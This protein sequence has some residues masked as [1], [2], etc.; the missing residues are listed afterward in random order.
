[1]KRMY[2]FRYVI[3]MLL[4]K[5]ERAWVYLQRRVIQSPYSSLLLEIVTCCHYSKR[6]YSGEIKPDASFELTILV[7]S[8]KLILL[9]K[10]WTWPVIRVYFVKKSTFQWVQKR[11]ASFYHWVCVNISLFHW[12]TSQWKQLVL[13]CVSFV[14]RSSLKRSSVCQQIVP[15]VHLTSDSPYYCSLY[16]FLIFSC[17]S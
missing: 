5:R 15:E 11:H 7:C 2:M 13:E 14:I 8:N 16:L 12:R 10:T 4:S 9:L 3:T 1:M 6:N 17:T